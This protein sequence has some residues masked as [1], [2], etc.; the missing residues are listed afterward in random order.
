[1]FYYYSA[2]IARTD[3]ASDRDAAQSDP[4]QARSDALRPAASRRAPSRHSHFYEYEAPQRGAPLLCRLPLTTPASA[5]RGASRSGRAVRLYLCTLSHCIRSMSAACSSDLCSVA[6]PA[7]PRAM[8]CA[9]GLCTA[10]KIFVFINIAFAMYSGALLATAARLAWD[11]STYTWFRFLCAAQ[12]RVSAAYVLAAGV[13]L[14]ALVYLAAAAT[15]A[16][17][18]AP[19]CLHLYAC[20]VVCLAASEV[21]YGAWM[22]ASLAAWWRSAPQAELARRGIDLLHDIKP[23]LLAVERYRD[24]ARPLYDMIEE[25]EREA[26]NN[27]FVIAVFGVL[28]A[29]LQVA[30]FVMARK[31][32]SRARGAREAGA[33][34]P[35]ADKDA[36]SACDDDSDAGDARHPPPGWTKKANLRMYTILDKIF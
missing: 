26:P 22:G 2:P 21:G 35:A 28:G 27:A 8:G 34:A 32:A 33:R 31:L 19:R 15:S 29:V 4:Q 30:A 12:Y 17:H 24:V 3:H 36:T 6:P 16:A 14:A 9:R 1:M 7:S 13:W 25:V 18:A 11:P 23:A 5:L 10:E 20:G